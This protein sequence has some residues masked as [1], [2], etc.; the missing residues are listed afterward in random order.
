MPIEINSVTVTFHPSVN[1]AQT[2]FERVIVIGVE[3]KFLK[4]AMEDGSQM[5]FRSAEVLGVRIVPVETVD[6]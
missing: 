1:F 4:L 6:T 3:G 2:E 5:W